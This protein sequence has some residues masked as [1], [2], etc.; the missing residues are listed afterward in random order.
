MS[1]GVLRVLFDQARRC[2]ECSAPLTGHG[3]RRFCSDECREPS[4]REAARDAYRPIYKYPQRKLIAC[5][6]CGSDFIYGGSSKKPPQVCPDQKCQES[7][8]EAVGANWRRKNVAKLSTKAK[9][10]YE[11]KDPIDHQCMRCGRGFQSKWEKA[12]YCKDCVK[13]GRLSSLKTTL[14]LKVEWRNCAKCSKKF[15]PRG[16]AQER[17]QGFIQTFC[18]R[19]CADA[20]RRK[21]ASKDEY[22]QALKAAREMAR[23][24]VDPCACT[25]CGNLFRPKSKVTKRCPTCIEEDRKPKSPRKCRVCGGAVQRPNKHSCS[26]WCANEL[27]KA[28]NKI[29]KA[30]RRGREKIGRVETVVVTRVFDRDGW[31]CQLCGVKTPKKLRGTND[32]RAPELDHIV[33]LARGGEHSYR[34]TQCAC[35]RCNGLKSAGPGGQLRLFG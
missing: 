1:E 16:P 18:S 20:G 8:K 11:A 14:E 30:R 5:K 35:R 28:A 33:P 7:R 24:Q 17:R 3:N 19:F 10:R 9:A 27:R 31:R 29:R 32:D 13:P 25:A 21:Y 4:K 2:V 26:D 34:N 22:R 15:R 6:I 12:K 23:L